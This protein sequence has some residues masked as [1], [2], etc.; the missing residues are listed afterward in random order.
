[1]RKS[2][3]QS[4]VTA[5]SIAAAVLSMF[6]VGMG[7]QYMEVNLGGVYT[8]V[9]HAGEQTFAIPAVAVILAWVLG[10]GASFA[11][12]RVRL[13]TRPEALCVF[14]AMALSAPLMSQGLWQR[15]VSIVA[16]IPRGEDF[17]KLDLLSDRLWPHGPN[18]LAE[19]FETRQVAAPTGALRWTESK[20]RS[21]L[22]EPVAVLENSGAGERVAVSMAVPVYGRDGEPILREGE[23]FLITALVRPEGLE[24]GG[25]FASTS[26]YDGRVVN[27]ATGQSL[28]VFVSNLAGEVNV[29][30]P[31]G[32]RRVGRYGVKLDIGGAR[33]LLVEVGLTG[34]GRLRI[35]DPRMVSVDALETYHAGQRSVT[36]ARYDELS[37]IE[38]R[39]LVVQPESPW[40]L[41]AIG[42]AIG[43]RVPW[44]DWL[45]PMTNWMAMIFL[46]LGGSL[47]LNV[48]FRRQWMDRERCQLPMTRIPTG[49]IGEPTEPAAGLPAIFRNRI[50]WAGFAVA[51]AW[52]LLRGWNFYEARVPD[53][54]G[55]IP[56]QPYFSDPMWG[57]TF[58]AVTFRVF[59]IFLALCL[60]ME[61]GVLG[62]IVIGYALYRAQ[63]YVGAQTDLDRYGGFPYQW[64]Q[65]IAAYVAYALVILF[66]ARR[67][68][69]RTLAATVRGIRDPGMDSPTSYRL[70]YAGLVLVGAGGFAWSR[71]NGIPAGGM[72]LYFAV[73]LAIALVASRIRV[74]VGTPFAFF[75]PRN[76]A[77]L[78]TMLGGVSIFGAD[79]ALNAALVSFVICSSSFF[80][81]PGGQMELME[82]GRRYRMPAWNAVTVALIAIVG[83]VLIGG[84]VFLSNSYAV[85]G[86]N[87]PYRWPY[88]PKSWHFH[89]FNQ[90]IGEASAVM[91][92]EVAGGGSPLAEPS[93][94]ASLYAGALVVGTAALRQLIPGF[95]FHPAGVV[96]GYADVAGNF[97]WGS[98]LAALVI[99]LLVVK[100]GGAEA[101]RNMLRPFAIG[102]FLGSVASVLIWT[103]YGGYLNARGIDMIYRGI[104]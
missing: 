103:I 85:G 1:M 12:F 95:W 102:L 54:S 23:P 42:Q 88:E 36:R 87:Q 55:V 19:G 92:G 11:L 89:S 5:R 63:Y 14:Y 79:V 37:P 4:G 30:Q 71:A 41:Q 21:T 74:D 72:M 96:I 34:A 9:A 75:T 60:F 59:A 17:A 26:R 84:W 76:A 99:R 20:V 35:A 101:V 39:G 56:L 57:R 49:L 65:Q 33:S 47:A 78:L 80:L 31:E 6:L 81:I 13:L 82:L 18:L 100:I 48:L 53:M 25:G 32:F 38:R 46:I 90:Q 7:I 3:G 28:E 83:G 58:E 10:G 66:L 98:A 44:R 91:R 8:P 50:M 45:G 86:D 69:S 64:H 104:P 2:V 27:P 43:G 93:T 68:L 40:S 70:A 94:I 62:S 97:I 16:T 15:V 52:C 22:A 61:L 73:T 67:Y 24:P 51:L 29:A 77:L